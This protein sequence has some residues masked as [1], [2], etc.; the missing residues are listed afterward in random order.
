MKKFICISN[1]QNPEKFVAGKYIPVDNEKL[2]YDKEVHYPIINVINAF[3]EPNEEVELVTVIADY[4]NSKVNYK[5][6]ISEVEELEKAQ[7]ITVKKTEC[8]IPYD[9]SLDTQLEMFEKLIANMKD[10][11]KLYCDITYGTK[12]MSQILTMSVNYG[13]RVNNNVTLGCIV[14]G[15]KEHNTGAQKIY[16]IT[17]L[18]YL[19]EIVRMMAETKVKEPLKRI[20]TLLKWG[21]SDEI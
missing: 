7:N 2:R 21:D 16:D 9:S 6:L 8:S 14:Y 19:D 17:S 10:N 15:E 1:F 4:D 18:N 13:Y 12:V 20:R 5:T 11:D 3:A